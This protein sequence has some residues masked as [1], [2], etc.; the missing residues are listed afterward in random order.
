[1]MIEKNG[2]Y[3]AGFGRDLVMAAMVLLPE[4]DIGCG[5]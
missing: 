5:L 3:G 4:A 1:M 2:E